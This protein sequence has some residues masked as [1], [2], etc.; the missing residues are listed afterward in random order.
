MIKE[1]NLSVITAFARAEVKIGDDAVY[2]W[3]ATEDGV[4]TGH[5]PSVSDVEISTFAERLA[6]IALENSVVSDSDADSGM[7]FRLCIGDTTE[8]DMPDD[9]PARRKIIRLFA[10]FK[11]ELY[12]LAFLEN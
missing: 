8:I 9:T 7:T 6:S 12:P 2:Y 5:V 11:P 1:I 4:D 10:D 3:F